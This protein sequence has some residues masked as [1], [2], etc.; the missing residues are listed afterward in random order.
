[1]IRQCTIGPAVCVDHKHAL[2]HSDTLD[3]HSFPDDALSVGAIAGI[4]V[5]MFLLSAR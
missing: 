2:C 3:F 1:M 5:G 4:G